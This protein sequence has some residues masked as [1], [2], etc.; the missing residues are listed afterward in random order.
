MNTFALLL[1]LVLAPTTTDVDVISIP[2]S[3]DVRASLTLGARAEMRRE[4][5]VSRIRI[6][7]DKIGAP[8]M[9]GPALHT[10]VVWVTSPEGLVENL[11][12]LDIRGA[13]A[14]FLNGTRFTQFGLLITAEPH[15][16]VDRPSSALVYRSQAPDTD[17]R[18]KTVQVELGAYNY[19]QIKPGAPAVLGVV[20]QARTAFQIA[21]AAGADRLTP[22]D[23]RNAQVALAAMDELVSRA[24]PIDIIWP[25]ANEAIRW[26]QRAAVVARAKR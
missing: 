12:E 20:N 10:F 13:R 5:S 2:V 15:Y 18:K 19:A 14:Q 3:G 9:F 16:M 17:F 21:Q 26:A 22:A 4:G 24:A 23:F 6:D 25:S 7:I 1:A 8:S 11:G